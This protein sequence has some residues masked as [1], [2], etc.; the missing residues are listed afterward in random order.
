VS[1]ARRDQP[2]VALTSWPLVYSQLLRGVPTARDWWGES[3]DG[4][5]TSTPP[6][7]EKLTAISL[8]R[9]TSGLIA[10]FG[11]ARFH[12]F[13]QGMV[14][15]F[16]VDGNQRHHA[17]FILMIICVSNLKARTGVYGLTAF[18]NLSLGKMSD[19]MNEGFIKKEK[20]K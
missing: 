2:D 13:K 14:S 9:Q 17:F 12:G 18:D 11:P 5:E 1:T 4:V 8:E 20:D 3:R 15:R 7:K 16:C 19:P 6:P 10:T